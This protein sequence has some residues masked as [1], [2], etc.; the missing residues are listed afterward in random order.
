MIVAHLDAAHQEMLWE[1]LEE[2]APFDGA[3]N[4]FAMTLRATTGI[5][6]SIVVPLPDRKFRRPETP[7]ADELDSANWLAWVCG[8]GSKW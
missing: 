6:T 3:R 1:A 4:N 8:Y 5:V 7:T 2:L